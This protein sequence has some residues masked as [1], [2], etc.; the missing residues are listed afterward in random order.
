LLGCC[1]EGSQLPHFFVHSHVD[2]RGVIPANG[3][4]MD[5]I[6][7]VRSAL[8]LHG[9]H[10]DQKLI[11]TGVLSAEWSLSTLGPLLASWETATTL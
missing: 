9:R 7:Q 3:L 4:E 10:S 1:A 6:V 2:R 11:I 8:D 5:S